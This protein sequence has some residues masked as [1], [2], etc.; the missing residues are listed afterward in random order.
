M[1]STFNLFQ[2]VAAAGMSLLLLF[3]R[4]IP[5]GAQEW[6]PTGSMNFARVSH[7]ATLLLDG[8]ILVSGGQDASGSAIAPA[9]IF[10]PATGTWSLTASNLS[11]RYDHTATL[12]EDGRLLVVGGVPSNICTFNSTAELYDPGSENWLPTGTLPAPVGTGHIAIRLLDGRVLAAGGGNRCGGVFSTAALYDPAS[13]T[14]SAVGNMTIPREFHSAI[15][16]ADGRVLVAGGVSSSPFLPQASAEI[17]DPATGVWASVGSMA[18][19]RATSCNGYMQSYLAV[20]KNGDV[21]AAASVATAEPGCQRSAPSDTADVFNPGSLSWTSTAAMTVPRSFTTLTSLN[22]GRVLVAGGFDGTSRLSS[23]ESYDPATGTWA[24]TAS[25]TSPRA[26]HTATRLTDGRVLVAGGRL[27]T[28]ERTAT[29]EIYN[30]VIAVE[31]EI[32]IKPGGIPNSINPRSQ[33]LIPVAILTTDIFDATIVD[34]TTVLFGAT[35]AEAAPVN[36]AFEDIDGD[37]DTDMILHFSTQETGIL[38]GDTFAF[39]TG[40]TLGSQVIEGSDSINTVGCR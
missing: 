36:S 39:L 12:L 10:N 20:L 5:V 35:G 15:L 27:A 1:K 30:S 19:T 13:G 3:G 28:G 24:P 40:I 22:D 17:F 37:L 23:A 18:T 7:Q 4:L 32:D 6:T 26:G 14:W 9:E 38:C 2:V 21:L 16:L 25:M 34:S 11:P 8:R 29:A 31:V 33:G